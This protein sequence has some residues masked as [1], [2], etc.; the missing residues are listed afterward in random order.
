MTHRTE[1]SS[2]AF[3]AGFAD[4]FLRCQHVA[5]RVDQDS[6]KLFWLTAVTLRP[7]APHLR[8]S[9]HSREAP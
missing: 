4:H 8:S 9:T 6:G 2:E 7:V 5:I 1:D 3:R